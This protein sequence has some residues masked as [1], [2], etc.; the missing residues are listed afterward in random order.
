M[1][2]LYIEEHST[3]IA[4][5]WQ[6]EVVEPRVAQFH[7]LAPGDYEQTFQD[8]HTLL[9]QGISNAFLVPATRFIVDTSLD[10][11]SHEQVAYQLPYEV[12]DRY[13]VALEVVRSVTK[14]A[15]KQGVFGR[16]YWN[17][18]L[19]KAGHKYDAASLSNSKELTNL[20]GAV[21]NDAGVMTG[22][23]LHLLLE[24]GLVEGRQDAIKRSLGLLAVARLQVEAVAPAYYEIGEPYAYSENLCVSQDDS[25]LRVRIKPDFL[26]TMRESYYK[27]DGCPIA[28]MRAHQAQGTMLQ[29]YWH[30]LVSFFIPD[31]ATV[32]GYMEPPSVNQS[33]PLVQ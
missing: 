33:T 26:R 20:G 6:S 11:L 21:F 22:G 18:D 29:N 30:Q 9:Q 25:G 4:Q 15:I 8:S 31:E 24:K 10:V 23:A 27:G 16:A 19:L 17:T 7:G 12:N 28:R 32:H 14:S 5:D 1:G 2:D 3:F 13:E